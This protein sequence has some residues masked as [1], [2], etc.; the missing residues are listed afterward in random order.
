YKPVMLNLEEQKEATFLQRNPPG[1]VPVLDT[2]SLSVGQS[3][4][5]A[6][7]LEERYPDPP[8]LPG[9][10]ESRALIREIVALIGCDTHPLQNLRVLNYLRDEFSAVDDAVTNW[11]QH[12]I[13]RS[14]SA[15]EKLVARAGSNG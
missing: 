6:E 13:G 11:I 15:C 9:D 3:L 12:W 8:L 14:F 7:Y 2:G 4:A 10:I 1:F 5:I